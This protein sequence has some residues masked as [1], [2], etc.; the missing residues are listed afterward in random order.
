[1]LRLL[2]LLTLL[3][4]PLDTL[5]QTDGHEVTIARVKYG[6]GGDWY[7]GEE[8]LPTLLAFVREH[9]LLDVA[10][11]EEIVELTS[12][13]LFQYPYLYLNGHGTVRF[14]DREAER[15]RRYLLGGGFL[16]VN[17]D[18]GLDATLRQEIRKVFPEQDF[19]RVPFDHPVYQAHFQFSNGLPK[20]HEHDGQ[21]AEGLGLFHEGRLVVFYSYESD[22]G[23]GW[24]PEGVHDNPP[25][26]R[27][28]ALRM[29]TN[30][31]IYAM[32]Q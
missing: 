21:P 11:R 31:L 23:D 12:D 27:Q 1:M 17:D 14:T 10:P 16:H 19:A 8:S 29:G 28:A 22:L 3:A 13:K 26:K 20:I 5:A 9:T 2:F 30:L 6:G 15:L 4:L 18:Y 32:T 7:S 25:E 24:E